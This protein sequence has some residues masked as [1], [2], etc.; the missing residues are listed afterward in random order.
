MATQ[1]R[2]R[3]MT[4]KKKR[5][6]SMLQHLL[7]SRSPY[8]LRGYSVRTIVLPLLPVLGACDAI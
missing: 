1:T 8:I 6:R 5:S 3:R 4:K 2:Y 7:L